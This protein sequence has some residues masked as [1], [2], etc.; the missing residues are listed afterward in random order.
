MTRASAAGAVGGR[1]LGALGFHLRKLEQV[2][3]SRQTVPA[4]KLRQGRRHVA[5]IG[6][7]LPFVQL[8]TA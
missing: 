5:D 7:G 2:A 4:R 6:R 8:V 1:L 3:E